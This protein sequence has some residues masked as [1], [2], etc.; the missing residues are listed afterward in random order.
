MTRGGAKAGSEPPGGGEEEG[1]SPDIAP[2]PV[3]GNSLLHRGHPPPHNL[4]GSKAPSPA[5]LQGPRT[6]AASFEEGA[7]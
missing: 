1:A 7:R 2:S 6:P 5:C 4:E 3:P